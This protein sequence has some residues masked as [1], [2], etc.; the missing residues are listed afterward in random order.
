MDL[1]DTICAGL[2]VFRIYH[3]AKL[4]PPPG[5]DAHCGD[6]LSFPDLGGERA[7]TKPQNQAMLRGKSCFLAQF[8]NFHLVRGK[9][10]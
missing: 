10:P 7:G 4:A 3:P 1:V 8:K 9:K 2:E 5:R 6:D